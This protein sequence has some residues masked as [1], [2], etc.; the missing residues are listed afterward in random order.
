MFGI[1]HF[2]ILQFLCVTLLSVVLLLIEDAGTIQH[3]LEDA[4]TVQNDIQ[5]AEAIQ[6]DLKDAGTIPN[7]LQAIIRRNFNTVF[8]G[9][10][11]A[12][13]LSTGKLKIT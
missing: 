1:H 11:E 5:D 4:G 8:A 13:R 6:N 7:D 3:N 2:S 9:G 10:S 12:D